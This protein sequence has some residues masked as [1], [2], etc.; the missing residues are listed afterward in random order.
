M[1]FFKSISDQPIN[2]L[3]H[4]ILYFI[5]YLNQIQYFHKFNTDIQL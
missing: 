5:N 3:Y 4:H 2:E 1:S